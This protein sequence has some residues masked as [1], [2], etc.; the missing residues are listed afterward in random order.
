ME[1]FKKG[2]KIQKKFKPFIFKNFLFSEKYKQ[3][4][5]LTMCES[6]RIT[7]KNVLC[8]SSF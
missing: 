3:Q 1:T 4:K 8:K 5:T 6:S 2:L 7:Y